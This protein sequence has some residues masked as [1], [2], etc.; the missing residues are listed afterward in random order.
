VAA[1]VSRDCLHAM[2]RAVTSRLFPPA[3]FSG[4]NRCNLQPLTL[5]RQAVLVALRTRRKREQTL[6]RPPLIVAV[7]TPAV[8]NCFAL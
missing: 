5:F 8:L 3:L 2:V 1:A 7:T 4:P 6:H